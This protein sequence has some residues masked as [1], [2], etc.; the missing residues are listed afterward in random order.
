MV[1]IFSDA[2]R[3][4]PLTQVQTA[5]SKLP[6]G[7]A[8]REPYAARVAGQLRGGDVPE[9]TADGLRRIDLPPRGL[10][11]EQEDNQ[12]Q[13][14]AGSSREMH[15]TVTVPTDTKTRSCPTLL[16]Y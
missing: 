15:L 14:G 13:V 7:P 9:R 16:Y 4:P 3:L 12:V 2:Q 8:P 10:T 6:C 5:P 11:V 1:P